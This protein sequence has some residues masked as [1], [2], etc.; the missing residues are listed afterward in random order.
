MR[1][2]DLARCAL[3]SC[4]GAAMLAGCGESQAP[5]GA[6]G[7][8]VQA[9]A[10]AMR[11]ERRGSWMLPEA[12]QA[13]RLLYAADGDHGIVH[14]YNY[15]TG[16]ELGELTGLTDP[17]GE[18]VDKTGDIFLTTSIGSTGAVLEYAHGGSSPITTFNTDG[19]PIG[20]S[21][22]PK[23][24]DLAVNNG[25]PS[26]GSDVE[27]WENASGAP[28]SYVNQQDC[29]EMWP[30]GYDNKG[31]L[32]IETGNYH[33]VCELATGGA[34]LIAVRLNHDIGFPGGVMWDGKYLTFTDQIYGGK[35]QAQ[36][37]QGFITA[38]YRVKENSGGLDVVG[39]TQ[40]RSKQCNGTQVG[41]PFIVGEKN[42]PA[43]HEQG[44][45]VVGGNLECQ[46][47]SRE[48]TPLIYWNYPRNG[49]PF[50][51][52]HPPP[53]AIAVNR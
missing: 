32:F 25:I 39:T 7:A 44:N 26:G 49:R 15:D 31:N 1:I 38:I 5:I 2:R 41:Q 45:A 34:S 11:A 16:A 13:K 36:E 6:P 19:H 3:T 53:D 22:N 8:M 35:T 28:T 29:D 33:S 24:G 43:N 12:K 30:P 37:D 21:I 18:C 9:S 42:T 10:V 48:T 14:V 50:K 23:S 46:Q 17:Y 47:L 4:A 20:C 27:I 40:L 51:H 52:I